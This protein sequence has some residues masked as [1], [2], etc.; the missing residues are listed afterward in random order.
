MKRMF[1]VDGSNHAFRVQFA[2]PPRHASDGFPTRVL[3]GFTLL[4]QKMLRT[5][6]PDYVVVAFDKGKTFRHDMYPPYK[7]HRPDMPQ[8]LRQQ[9][10]HLPSLV[11][12][13]GYKAMTVLG[14][15]ADDVLGTLA[16]QFA[17]PELEVLLVTGDKDFCQLVDDNIKILDEKKN[18]VIDR[19][20]VIEKFGVPPELVIDVLGLAGDASDNIPGITKVGPKTALKYLLQYGTLEGVLAAGRDGL[21]KGKTGERV[22]DEGDNARLSKVL[23]TIALDVPLGLTL[24]DLEPRGIQGDLMRELFDKWEFGLVARKLLPDVERADLSKHRIATEDD[25]EAALEAARKESPL[26]F[27][28]LLGEGDPLAPAL[29][30]IAVALGDEGV[31][32]PLSLPGARDAVM[33]MLA[34]GELPKVGHQVK[35]L[36]RVAEA[37][38]GGLAGIVGDTRILDY[39]LAPHRKA[40]SLEDQASRNLGHTMGRIRQEDPELKLAADTCE[41]V[42]VIRALHARQLPKAEEGQVSVFREIELPLTPILAAMEGRGIR[43][44]VEAL[45]A[46]EVDIAGR[47]D[48]LAEACY[49]AAGKTFNLRSRHELREV[50]FDDL[51]LPPGKKVSDGWSTASTVLEKL[52][53][54]HALPGRILEFRS[55]EKLRSTYLSKLPTWVAADGRIHSNFRQTVAAT[56][57]LAS[58]DPNLQ[59]IPVRTFEGRRIRQCFV[60]ADGCVFLS[61]DY[62]QVELRVLAHFCQDPILLEGFRGNIDIHRRTASE[63]FGIPYD[64]VD[65]DRR[66]AAKAINFGLLYGMSAFRLAGDL[67]I[68]RE[69]AVTYMEEYFARMPAVS[70]WIEETKAFVKEHGYVDTLYGRRRV[71]PE[72][73]SAVYTERMQGE[74]EAV[75]TRI[76][77]TAADIIKLAMLRVDAA[78]KA[79]GLRS[80]ILLQ[81]HDELLLEVPQDESLLATM[82]VSREMQA[83]ASLTV[84]L[85]VNT[86]VG[87]NWNEAHG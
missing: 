8:D 58:A 4:F 16:K 75:N 24:E 2:L 19:A 42:N 79:E 51:K 34:D 78:L 69:Q 64:E 80:R 22:R 15:E 56:G 54:L 47:I 40:H 85:A 6:R 5:W 38:G 12:G 49:E 55:M 68:S 14:Y 18:L 17:S 87:R 39:L 83:A 26:H 20:G 72:I 31:Y 7:G 36:Y 84:P 60:P 23:A 65:S 50:L 52:V 21:I 1:L 82:L 28:P 29:A 32:I 48:V 46:V 61:A 67:A 44:D 30:G 27:A 13:F 70:G 86:S 53:D 25:V 62:S 73:H 45:A 59:N 71:I 9:W 57:R 74:R 37:H 35:S 66:S 33:A 41:E 76:Q 3:Y 81:V 63:V 43:L 10:D 77:G 11:E